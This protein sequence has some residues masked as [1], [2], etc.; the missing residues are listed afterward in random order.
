MTPSGIE[1]ANFRF[2]AQH[3]NHWLLGIESV[4]RYSVVGTVTSLR[5]VRPDDRIPTGVS[6]GPTASVV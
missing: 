5:A 3:L 6:D 2:V 4:K 1:T